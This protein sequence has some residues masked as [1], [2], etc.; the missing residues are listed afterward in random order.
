MNK[1]E[2]IY[3]L[4]K[5]PDR[6]TLRSELKSHK[7]LENNDVLEKVARQVIA[8]ANRI[9]GYLI[10][11]ADNDGNLE[12][13][14]KF[15]FYEEKGRINNYL[16]DKISP[17]VDFTIEY[18][19]YEDGDIL[20]ITVSPFKDI[21]HAII[22][23]K[24]PHIT[25]RQYYYRTSYGINLVSDKQL[26]YLFQSKSLDFSYLFSIIVHYDEGFNINYSIDVPESL[27]RGY[28]P[29]MANLP[30]QIKQKIL[31]NEKDI[32]IFFLEITPYLLLQNIAWSFQMSWNVTIEKSNKRIYDRIIPLENYNSKKISI[33]NLPNLDSTF[34][35]STLGLDLVSYLE[36][37]SFPEFFV[38][39]ELA[40]GD[41]T[42]GG[43][44]VSLILS[45]PDFE[46][47]LNFLKSTGGLYLVQNEPQFAYRYEQLMN[48]NFQ[49]IKGEL[50]AGFKFPETDFHA[51]DDFIRYTKN[52]KQLLQEEWSHE[53]FLSTQPNKAQYQTLKKL[54]DIYSRLDK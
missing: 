13:K 20:V 26:Q 18:F 17:T 40:Y 12:G 46:L 7:L 53:H 21:P 4:I 49:E 43:P 44:I 19:E 51:F 24:H 33:G 34:Y 35:L 8:F 23:G 36:K 6:E 5:D 27:L 14:G 47:K 16:Y 9:G 41:K 15:N 54:D 25:W 28:G 52:I 48:L 39:A 42:L 30:I 37:I 29:F 22:Q 31:N 2:Y 38:P 45:H 50:Q 1:R 11:G 32:P 3:K 10:I